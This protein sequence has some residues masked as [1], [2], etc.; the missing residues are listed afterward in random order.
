MKIKT[1]I[2]DLWYQSIDE[3][4]IVIFIELPN[5]NRE[6][7]LAEI[8]WLEHETFPQEHIYNECLQI[9]HEGG[10]YL[11]GEVERHP[12]GDCA[13]YPDCKKCPKDCEYSEAFQYDVGI[14]FTTVHDDYGMIAGNCIIYCNNSCDEVIVLPFIYLSSSTGTVEILD[15]ENV[16][17]LKEKE[18]VEATLLENLKLNLDWSKVP[19]LDDFNKGI[20]Y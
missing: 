20:R 19:T 11:E 18:Q 2:T 8:E 15:N 16:L 14:D 9:A 6:Y 17:S 3:D 13:E 4:N 1:I 5:D 12:C 10:Y 7:I